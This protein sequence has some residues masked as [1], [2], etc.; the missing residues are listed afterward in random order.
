M[1][2]LHISP[3]L[4]WSRIFIFPIA[5]KQSMLG[6][7]V[8][9]SAPNDPNVK[10]DGNLNFNVVE[11]SKK[12]VNFFY[13]FLSLFLIIFKI[14]RIKIDKVYAHTTVDSFGY[15]LFIRLFTRAKITYINHGVPFSGYSGFFKFILKFFE[16]ININFSHKVV[17][18]T[19]SMATLLESVNKF[20]KK[21][22]I[23]NPGTLVG[24]NL[25]YKTYEELLEVRNNQ[26]KTNTLR[27]IYVGRVEERK[28]IVELIQAINNST[29]NC[30]LVVLGGDANQLNM[31]FDNSKIFF[32]GFKSDLSKYYLNSDILCVP[33][34]H[35]GFGQV[36]LEAA[37]FG[38]IP[39]CSNIPG[40]TDFILHGLNGFVVEPKSYNSIELLL[41]AIER[42]EFDLEL[43]R[44]NSFDSVLKFEKTKVIDRNMV[45]FK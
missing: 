38:V 14:H 5:E 4:K 2:I 9:I 17:T 1:N 10:I 29:I 40:P 26:P 11:W 30:E 42:K 18:I 12:Y 6:N 39:V 13:Y 28:G 15:I 35:E 20:N 36:Y 44:K 43:I 3:D 22:H 34:H 7:K 23:M 27:I 41:N 16:I 45:Y 19:D 21:I 37:S 24:V 33:S 8:W 31:S 32:L 25:Y